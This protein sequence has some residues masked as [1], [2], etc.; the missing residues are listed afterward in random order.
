MFPSFAN[1][2]MSSFIYIFT[3]F[4]I[5]VTDCL[6]YWLLIILIHCN[7]MYRIKGRLVSKEIR[8]EHPQQLI[9]DAHKR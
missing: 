4:G 7:N 3:K 9:R 6:W 2:N 8:L 5:T 1:R